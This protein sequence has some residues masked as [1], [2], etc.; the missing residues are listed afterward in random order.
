M[1][2]WLWLFAFIFTRKCLG[3]KFEYRDVVP[4][5]HGNAERR[6]AVEFRS[7]STEPK[8]EGAKESE[9]ANYDY[10]NKK[11]EPFTVEDVL[12]QQSALISDVLDP[13]DACFRIYNECI[14]VNAQPYERRFNVLLEECKHRCMQ[15]QNNAYS[16]RLL[17]YDIANEICDF[18]AHRG[19]QL[20][21]KLLKYQEHLCLEP[22]FA[23]GCDLKYARKPIKT[24]DVTGGQV[25]SAVSL[26]DFT[27]KDMSYGS[28]DEGK[29]V[30]YLRTQGFEFNNVDRTDLGAYSLDTCM[31]AC[32][33]NID[34]KGYTFECRSFDYNRTRCSLL[35]ESARGRFRELKRNSNANY[36]E[37]IC[38]DAD[39]MS[40]E[41]QTINR[42]PQMILVGFAEAVITAK[43]FMRCFESCLKSRQLFAINCTSVLYFYEESDQNCIL[44]SEN[45][46][47]QKNLFVEE[48]TDVVDYFEISCPIKNQKKVIGD[49]LLFKS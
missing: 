28:C 49:S 40:N 19:D 44:N 2:T 8:P 16:C 10:S 29:V 37:K 5:N 34:G 32:T 48:N 41:C 18:F 25:S 7:F 1:K 17:V 27:K 38:V 45:R 31:N 21:A 14:I 26:V 15:T 24:G 3:K 39:L 22:T 36:Y 43:S 35:A 47:T 33:N 13:N 11:K 12:L 4:T 30:K 23:S 46:K 20:P 9:Q 42:F 6:D